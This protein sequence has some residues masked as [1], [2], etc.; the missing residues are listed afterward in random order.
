MC[1]AWGLLLRVADR[2]G[3]SLQQ[4]GT[5]QS[6]GAQLGGGLCS[7]HC[8]RGQAHHVS[9]EG[10][11]Q[12]AALRAQGEVYRWARCI[13]VLPQSQMRAV[14]TPLPE[15]CLEVLEPALAWEDLQVSFGPA[16]RLL[17]SPAALLHFWVA[18]GVLVSGWGRC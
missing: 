18:G 6:P 10:P 8:A 3:S 17:S 7:Q 14:G 12:G 15:S 2:P 1:C 4:L 11:S 16:S 9:V 5:V 13:R